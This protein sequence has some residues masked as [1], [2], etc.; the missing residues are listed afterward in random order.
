MI[1]FDSFTF[2]RTNKTTR[3]LAAPVKVPINNIRDAI[4]ARVSKFLIKMT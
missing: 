3:P 1:L 4:I 2:L